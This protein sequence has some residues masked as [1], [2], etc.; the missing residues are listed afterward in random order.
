[1]ADN[2]FD[3]G[4]ALRRHMFG[5]A[6]AERQLEGATE[7]TRPLQE[8]VTRSCFGELWHRPH[9][10]LKLRSMLTIAMLAAMG[11]PNQVK[12]HVKG[13]LANGVS[14]EEI[15]EILLHA[16]TYGGLPAAVDGFAAAAEAFAEID[17]A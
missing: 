14:R 12:V 15:R 13:A 2:D 16:M 8:L 7:F 4:L 17:A 9:L 5:P 10:D 1:M 3:R 6:G 11:K